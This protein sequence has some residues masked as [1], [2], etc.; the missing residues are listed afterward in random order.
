MKYSVYRFHFTAG[1]HFGNG[2]LWD[3]ETALP[4]DTLFSALCQEAVD[5]EGRM[6]QRHWRRRWNVALCD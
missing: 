1:V 2:T 3:S 6:A 4:A 5:Q